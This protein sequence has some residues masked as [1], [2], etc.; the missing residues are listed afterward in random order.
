MFSA[1][2]FLFLRNLRFE[3]DLPFAY[4]IVITS[5]VIAHMNARLI[6][7][8]TIFQ[9]ANASLDLLIPLE[10]ATSFTKFKT[11]RALRGSEVTKGKVTRGRSR[12]FLIV[13]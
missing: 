10:P 5:I 13:I 1:L 11:L 3:V 12:N 7:F 2:P 4:F 9:R 8:I 6:C